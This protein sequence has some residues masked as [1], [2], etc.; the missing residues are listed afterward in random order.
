VPTTTHSIKSV[1]YPE[2]LRSHA[3]LRFPQFINAAP[4]NRSHRSPERP[5]GALDLVSIIE[6]T[7]LAEAEVR[8]RAAVAP[9]DSI[10]AGESGIARTHADAENETAPIAHGV[11]ET[12][13]QFA[14]PVE[15][16][17]ALSRRVSTGFAGVLEGIAKDGPR[18]RRDRL[19]VLHAVRCRLLSYT[20]L[21]GLVFS[22]K[23]RAVV[24][25]RILALEKEGWLRTWEERVPRGG[26]PRYALPT[27]K[28][29][30]WARHVFLQESAETPHA[31]LAATM[32]RD[33]SPIPLELQEGVIPKQLAHQCETNDIVLS[34]IES[35]LPVSWATSWHRPF[36]N[37][38]EHL[39][40]PQPDAVIVMGERLVF[41]EHDRGHEALESF[42]R[43]KAERYAALHERRDI[44]E[45]LTGFRA[46]DVVVTIHAPAPLERLRALQEVVRTTHGA[47]MLRFTLDQ[48]LVEA[49]RE[50]ICFDSLSLPESASPLRASHRGL[51][52]LP[53]GRSPARIPAGQ[54]GGSR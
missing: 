39:A 44:L 6:Q 33:S 27:K 49:P 7:L 5:F 30:L 35:T 20:Q 21:H 36:P 38:V 14:T 8:D 51:L 2:T 18:L 1:K 9:P 50:A 24:G 15:T 11:A 28:A 3:S 48:W 23:H 52:P 22:G 46:F 25:R 17:E 13:E 34:L 54:T 31:R 26:H 19:L 45:A 29:L 10:N 47:S 43:A 4:M 16:S 12:A 41:I 40:L 42:R 53:G 37:E 32:L